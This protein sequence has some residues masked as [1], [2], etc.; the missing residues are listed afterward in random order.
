M[1]GALCLVLAGPVRAQKPGEKDEGS[2]RAEARRILVQTRELAESIEK[3]E[4]RNSALFQ[5]VYLFARA[6]DPASAME[7][8]FEGEDDKQLALALVAVGEAES[9]NAADAR[10]TL[11]RIRY[12]NYRANAL[13]QIAVALARQG[14][15]EE[16]AGLARGLTDTSSRVQA[17]QRIAVELAKREDRDAAAQ[18][19]SEAADLAFS[20]PYPVDVDQPGNLALEGMRAV[21]KVENLA[22]VGKAQAAIGEPTDASKTFR[23]ALD[24]VAGISHLDSQV[25]ARSLLAAAQADT[26]DVNGALATLEPVS[27][28]LKSG[29]V[30]FMGVEGARVRIA[31]ALAK[32]GD[33]SRALGIINGEQEP[34]D[35]SHALVQVAAELGT[36]GKRTVALR[37]LQKATE[38]GVGVQSEYLRASVFR[39]IGAAQAKLGDSGAAARSFGMAEQALSADESLR[40]DGLADLAIE[41]ARAGDYDAAL[42]SAKLIE[43]G[44]KR[45]EA[46]ER[47][48]HAQAMAGRAGEAEALATGESSRLVKVYLLIGTVR[49]LLGLPFLDR[50]KISL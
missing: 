29:W 35:R 32:Q 30:P 43:G 47:I 41:Q 39:D 10:V 26:G 21:H 38:T 31:M 7:I 28:D 11:E 17:L 50:G 4:H 42:H 46:M 45:S 34:Y 13:E 16:A 44:V 14:N 2:K 33:A 3:E 36:A 24:V 23:R 12:E 37:T 27:D 19:L 6:G 25:T 1:S 18:L 22:E 40:D 9:G 49:G 48:A 20:G 8:S 5:L 15:A